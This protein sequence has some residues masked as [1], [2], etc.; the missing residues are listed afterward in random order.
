[1]GL[2]DF[3]IPGD[4]FF[5]FIPGVGD[6]DD[7]NNGNDGNGSGVVGTAFTAAKFLT[8]GPTGFLVSEVVDA[9]ID[10]VDLGRVGSEFINVVDRF[11]DNSDI[12]INPSRFAN[13]V[14]SGLT[15]FFSA[16]NI[17]NRFAT[18]NLVNIATSNLIG[19][20]GLL[21]SFSAVVAGAA[22]GGQI[23]RFIDGDDG[24]N[25]IEITPEDALLEG[26]LRAL[27][28]SDRVLGTEGGDIANGN[29]GR[30][31]LVGREGADYLRGGR[32]ED[33][34]DGGPDNDIINGNKGDDDIRGG[35][36]DDILRGGQG[37]DTLYGGDGE[38]VLIGDRGSDFL[39]GGDDAD[40]F[41]LRGGLAVENAAEADRI[42]DFNSGEGDRIG[43]AKVS[44]LQEIQL[45]AED[46][47]GDGTTDTVILGSDNRVFG[48]VL[49][50]ANTLSLENDFFL[51]AAED[52]AID[53]IG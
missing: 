44:N 18:R 2:F 12:D 14:G 29:A 4:G 41:I 25:L 11:V 38:D 31:T 20:V 13:S 39:Y 26:G 5:D 46:I 15:E 19:D 30:D 51:V 23:G 22:I 48:V 21:G 7:D 3:L 40:D 47:N 52:T 9:A 16:G 35:D 27:G 33:I 36:G 6:D 43:L 1:M 10:N 28:G 49:D 8:L 42:I 50:T 34:L 24:D 45:S 32:N 53:T 17:I 37:N